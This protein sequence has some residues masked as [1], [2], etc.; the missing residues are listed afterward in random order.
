MSIYLQKIHQLENTHPQVYK[1]FQEDGLQVVQRSDKYWA[2]LSPD[3]VIEQALMQ[4][5]KTTG[6]LTRG[7]GMSETQRLVWVLSNPTTSEIN[8]AMQELANVTYETSEQH[9]D[10][11]ASRQARDTADTLKILR[12]SQLQDPVARYEHL[13]NLITGA[14]AH[15]TVNV[16]HSKQVG[17]RVLK[18][19]VG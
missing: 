13:L 9:K 2:G 5:K 17:K 14:T 12:L 15:N 4:S 3:L 1:T 19:M 10:L 16:D 18:D 6:G 8:N 7:R 11:S